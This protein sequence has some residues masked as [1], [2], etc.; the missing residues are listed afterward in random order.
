MHRSEIPLPPYKL[1]SFKLSCYFILVMN[2]SKS[3]TIFLF[4]FLLPYVSSGQD[5][6]VSGTVTSEETGEI[7]AGVNVYEPELQKG[8]I[9]DSDG[10]YRF[11]LPAGSHKI[12]FSFVG[13]E[14]QEHSITLKDHVSLDARL[15]KTSVQLD[16]VTISYDQPGQNTRST[17]MGTVS[18][19]MAAISNIPAFLGEVDVLKTIQLFPG[20][21]SAGDGNTGFFVRGGDADQN[22]VLFDNAQVY[23]ASHM[24]NFFSIF[25]PDAIEDVKLYK[26]GIPPSY[27][28]RLSSVL[29]IR[30]REG[31]ME[32]FGFNGGIGLISSRLSME[33][34]IQKGRSSF[35]LAGRRTYADMF[36]KLSTNENQRETRLYFYDFNA[37]LNYV[38]GDKNHVYVSAYHGRDITAFRQNFAFDWGN[39]T[40]SVRWV[41]KFSDS[42]TGNLSLMYSGYGFNISG[43]LEPSTFNWQSSLSNVNLQSGFTYLA[44]QNS[45]I[46]FGTSSIYHSLEPGSL[47]V[48]FEEATSLKRELSPSHA[49]EH[50]VYFLSE[51]RISGDRLALDYG[52]RLSLF[53][54]AGPGNKY[55]FDRSNQNHW[56]VT[57]TL[58]LENG[59]LYDRFSGLEPRVSLRVALGANSSIKAGYNRM[60]Q[61]IQQTQSS[62]SVAPYDVWYISSNN[63]PP[64]TADQVAL[65][66]FMNF[67]SNRVETSMEVYYKDI[68][69][70]SDVIDNGDI[71]GNE[72][73]ES[74]LRVGKGW[75]YGYEFMISGGGDRFDGF[76]GYTWSRTRRK[77]D[78]IN[79]GKSYYSPNDRRHDFSFSGSYLING[80]LS[81]SL[82]FVYASGRAFTLPVGKMRY[83]GDTA[84]IFAERNSGNLPDYHRLDMSFRYTPGGDNRS[85][86]FSSTWNFSLFNV[87]GRINPISVA[88]QRSPDDSSQ[89]SSFIYIPGPLPSVTWNFSF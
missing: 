88:F 68:S 30:M 29:D 77:I 86:K 7:L 58:I 70:I 54:V 23:N 10:H 16:E 21:L 2:I 45:N 31:N 28:G 20:V 14:N 69:N 59:E 24:F 75:S 43:N 40:G 65:G 41:R 51:H 74:Q 38:I 9:T 3:F 4:L 33:G 73:L 78:G 80:K 17:E 25:N 36:L 60:T 84:P 44:G 13:Y 64:Q 37:K 62:Q 81:M 76:A 63:I 22:L 79:E 52:I 12:I 48:D 85:R 19:N 34:P 89:R 27:G 53:Q 35:M 18:M 82:S 66:Y 46:S 32:Q 55:E 26:G 5:Y 8:V 72:F 87:Y 11:S 47:I 15:Q 67:L 57:D 6:T 56:R 83:Q 39:T 42:F 49:I 50:G 71:L 61:Y 1:T